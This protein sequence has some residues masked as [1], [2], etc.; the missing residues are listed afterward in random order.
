MDRDYGREIDMLRDELLQ[1]KGFMKDIVANV[2]ANEENTEVG[3]KL[4]FSMEALKRPDVDD[5]RVGRVF[6]MEA[7]KRPDVDN[8][9]VGHVEKMLN[10]HPD[11][12][13]MKL[14]GDAEDECGQEGNAGRV[15]YL[16]VFASGDRQSTWIKKN[17]NVDRLLELIE[18]RM[19]EKVLACIGNGDRLNIL[20]AIL[21][22][23]MTVAQLVEECKF[24]STGQAY[25]HLKPLIAADLVKEDAI[26]KGTYV[27]TPHRVQ[28]IVMLLAGISDMSDPEY[29]QGTFDE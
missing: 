29:T 16:G 8:P 7:P 18:N 12:A 20:L 10:M 14:L 15:T 24:G 3:A 4:P 19:A 22:K 11:K 9:R 2:M 27:I 23:P 28:G 17:V 1:I 5:P 13:I 26:N 21:R 6:S 25:H